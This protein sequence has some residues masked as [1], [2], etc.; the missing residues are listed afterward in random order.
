[1]SDLRDY[2]QAEMR[3]FPGQRS[4]LSDDDLPADQG[5]ELARNVEYYDGRVS[6]RR[7]FEDAFASSNSGGNRIAHMRHWLMP[8][9][10]RLVFLIPHASAP[11]VRYRNLDGTAWEDDIVTGLAAT[12][13]DADFQEYGSRMFMAFLGDAGGAAARPK[14]WN[15]LF[16]G[17]SGSG[18]IVDDAFLA[19]PTSGVD[20]TT[21]FTEPGAG[22]VDAG[23]HK[24]GLLFETRNGF[25]TK[26][27]EVTSPVFTA[28]GSMSLQITL[29]PT[30]TWSSSWFQVRPLIS[31]VQ[32]PD[33]FWIVP[34]VSAS[35]F[36]GSSS[37]V[38][39]SVNISDTELAAL[40]SADSEATDYFTT[41]VYGDDS[42]SLD[43]KALV[44][45]GGRMVW[46]YDEFDATSL[47]DVSRAFISETGD[48]QRG[49]LVANQ[50]RLPGNLPITTAFADHNLLY[51]VGPSWIYS[52]S[53]NLDE[54]ATW[55]EPQLVD[56]RVGTPVPHGL[57]KDPSR[58]L[59]WIAHPK[60]L[61][62]FDGGPIPD[63]PASYF[64]QDQWQRI[65]WS[66]PAGAI[67]VVV[68]GAGSRVIVVAPLDAETIPT[69]AFVWNYRNGH[70]YRRVDFSVLDFDYAALDDIGGAAIV[71]HN[72]IPEVWLAPRTTADEVQRQKSEEAGDSNILGRDGTSG[73]Y[74]QQYKTGSIP[75][76]FPELVNH[77][78]VHMNVRGAGPLATTAYD[79]D[80]TRSRALNPV[81]L[82]SAPGRMHKRYVSLK[83]EDLR[84]LFSNGGV[85]D[86]WFEMSYLRVYYKEHT[87]QR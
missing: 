29:T 33:R 66:A 37:A 69:S 68:D 32:N 31:T 7:G 12:V 62:V 54:P 19:P 23:V 25:T 6:P 58:G 9:W 87:K 51:L 24:I 83:S 85:V 71:H 3:D 64:E 16:I 82:A 50:I 43:A 13:T 78:A 2:R 52:V 49:N 45:Y 77:H 48:P 18:P 30:G 74:T 15:G 79:K 70:S 86:Q 27:I 41:Y 39:L 22:V 76:V 40:N 38:I 17:G 20:F 11:L 4:A 35:G 36:G 80:S 72:D 34:S 56:G 10:S 53:D 21:G 65:N 28:S 5:A 55:G 8:D 61:F 75:R 46:I 14:V 81:T 44:S 57:G 1:M 63:K 84:L 42:V 47:G 60:G 26:A 67:K 59:T 73:G